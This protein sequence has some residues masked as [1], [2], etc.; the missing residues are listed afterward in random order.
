MIITAKELRESVIPCSIT[1]TILHVGKGKAK[2]ICELLDD[3]GTILQS[4][5]DRDLSSGDKMTIS[6]LY[7]E[8]HIVAVKGASWVVKGGE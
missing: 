6:G 3:E 8:F 7:C 5:I 4:W 2:V 1:F